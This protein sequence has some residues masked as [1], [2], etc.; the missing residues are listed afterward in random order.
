MSHDRYYMMFARVVIVPRRFFGGS[1]LVCVS[2]SLARSLTFALSLALSR[3]LRRVS[4][5]LTAAVVHAEDDNRR[6]R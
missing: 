5:V 4:R 3:S 1:T 2:P 6:H